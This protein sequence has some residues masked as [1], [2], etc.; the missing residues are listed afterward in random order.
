MVKITITKLLREKSG[1]EVYL[2]LNQT[3][4]TSFLRK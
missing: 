1:S 4:M 3:Y 2:G